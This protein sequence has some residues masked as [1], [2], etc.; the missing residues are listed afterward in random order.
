M[1]ISLVL[2]AVLLSGCATTSITP[3]EQARKAAVYAQKAA[4]YAAEAAALCPLILN[5]E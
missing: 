3:C 5:D 2:C 4:D 1:K